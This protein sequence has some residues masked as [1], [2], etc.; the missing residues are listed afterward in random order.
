[1]QRTR[2]SMLDRQGAWIGRLWTRTRALPACC[3]MESDAVENAGMC[4]DGA[5]KDAR[6]K[7]ALY[8][9]Q[10]EFLWEMSN[11]SMRLGGPP[12]WNRTS[13]PRLGGMCT[14]HCAT[15]RTLALPVEPAERGGTGLQSGDRDGA[16]PLGV[17]NRAQL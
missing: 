2:Q 14:I 11:R 4:F 16:G 17:V 15:G 3:A 10:F 6:G 9:L 7:K 8:A 5:A 13:I 1:M 12:D